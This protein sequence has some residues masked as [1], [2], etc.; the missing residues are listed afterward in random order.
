MGANVSTLSEGTSWLLRSGEKDS[1][2]GP[3]TC[4][5]KVYYVHVAS[6]LTNMHNLPVQCNETTGAGR[7]FIVGGKKDEKSR[8]L[9][10]ALLQISQSFQSK[11][12][13]I[14]HVVVP[15]IKVASLKCRPMPR[16]TVTLKTL[17]KLLRKCGPIELNQR[18]TLLCAI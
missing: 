8:R 10:S 7:L 15:S 14:I 2:L 16:V 17:R 18:L 3:T 13:M 5:I 6:R 12:K 11:T 4:R 9:V 1:R